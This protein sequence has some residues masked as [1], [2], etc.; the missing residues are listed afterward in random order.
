ME[1]DLDG[2]NEVSKGNDVKTPGCCRTSDVMGHAELLCAC[3]AYLCP[4]VED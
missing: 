2:N 3:E 4:T 1:E